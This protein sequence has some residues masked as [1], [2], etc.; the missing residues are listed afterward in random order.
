MEV[1]RKLHEAFNQRD[2][3]TLLGCLSEDVVWHV[4]GN[5]PF[6]GAFA[7]RDGVWKGELEPLWE[8]PARLADREVLEHGEHAVALVEWFHNLGEGERGWKGVEVLRLANGRVAERR[9]L[10]SEQ[11]ELD[12]LFI[13]GCPADAGEAR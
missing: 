5:G 10:M 13:R 6:A 11:A 7:G 9:E 3:E 8:S 1:V 2:R 4:A 12:R